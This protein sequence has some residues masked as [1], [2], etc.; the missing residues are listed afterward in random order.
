VPKS[1]TPIGCNQPIN[2]RSFFRSFNAIFR[3]TGH[4]ASEEAIIKL[5]ESKCMHILMYGLD[6][7]PVLVSNTKIYRYEA[8]YE[9]IPN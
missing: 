3:K 5:I 2:L 8:I 4:L 1:Q 6:A 7:S 9:I